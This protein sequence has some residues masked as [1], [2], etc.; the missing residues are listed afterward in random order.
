MLIAHLVAEVLFLSSPVSVGGLDLTPREVAILYSIRPLL[1]AMLNMLLYPLMARRWSTELILRR[2]YTYI[3]PA[4]YLGYFILGY[5][6]ASAS[7]STSTY[8][9]TGAVQQ[10]VHL[11]HTTLVSALFGLAMLHVL[12]NCSQTATGQTLSSRAPSRLYLSRLNTLYEY[13]ANIAHGSGAF[14]GSNLWAVGV[15]YNILK[16]HFVW[17]FLFAMALGLGVMSRRVTREKTWEER[18]EEEEGLAEERAQVI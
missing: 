1:G 13:I 9:G 16:G 7:S 10:C 4:H 18:E 15:Q 8:A 12:D 5:T 11:S 6:A 14:V 3:L 17:L 2:C